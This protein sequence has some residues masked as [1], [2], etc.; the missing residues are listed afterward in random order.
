MGLDM[1]LSAKR[2]FWGAS[3]NDPAPKLAEV[4]APYEVKEVSVEVA[5]WRKANQI[6]AW[7]VRE[8]QDGEDE[9]KPHDVDPNKLKELRDLCADLLLCKDPKEAMEK[10]PPQEGFFFGVT[11]IDD[12]YWGDLQD[13][14]E[15]IDSAFKAFGVVYDDGE[16]S[17]DRWSF[18]YRSSW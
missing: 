18:E 17:F 10:L 6:H 3:L 14:V 16:V 7:F 8:V 13:T 4:P 9:C 11:E 5:Y 1:Y 12:G 2:Y 15:Q